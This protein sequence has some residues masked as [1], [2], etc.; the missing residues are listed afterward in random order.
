ML[1][2][3]IQKATNHALILR[4]VFLSFA[5][6]EVDASFAQGERYF[7]PILSEDEIFWWWEEIWDHHGL[8]HRFICVLCFRAHKLP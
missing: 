5:L 4:I 8:P 1:C 6:E 7:Y 2:V 3:C